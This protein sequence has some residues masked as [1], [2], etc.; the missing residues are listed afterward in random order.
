ML[1]RKSARAIAR[2]C[3]SVMLR[4]PSSADPRS[5]PC[6]RRSAWKMRRRGKSSRVSGTV[7]LLFCSLRADPA[8]P[9]ES[10]GMENRREEQ[11]RCCPAPRIGTVLYSGDRPLHCEGRH[12]C[13]GVGTGDSASSTRGRSCRS[14]DGKCNAGICGECNRT[15]AD[16]V[17]ALYRGRK[18]MERGCPSLGGSKPKATLVAVQ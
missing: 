8:L 1:S 3:G 15:K 10:G 13:L 14:S 6:R 11:S 5:R 4:V 16:P 9:R 7:V 17:H 2:S 12:Y 18:A